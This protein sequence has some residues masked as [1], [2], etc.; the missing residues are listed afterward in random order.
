M[1][2]NKGTK[3]KA[4]DYGS[5]G[6]SPFGDWSAYPDN[7]LKDWVATGGL[8]QDI[9]DSATRAKELLS[10]GV[11]TPPQGMTVEDAI[12]SINRGL[13]DAESALADASKFLDNAG[14][15][16]PNLNASNDT[17]DLS[18]TGGA[19]AGQTLTPDQDAL[20][21]SVLR[22][23][24]TNTIGHTNA[25]GLGNVQLNNLLDMSDSETGRSLTIWER[26]T[27]RYYGKNNDRLLFLAR[28]EFIRQEAA[29]KLKK[30][31]A[32]PLAVATPSE[33]KTPPAKMQ[34]ASWRN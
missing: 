12:D 20:S 1:M 19:T 10:A 14:N 28:L 15:G 7:P 29:Q 2:A 34:P 11:A 23:G 32:P 21:G 27:R 6:W 8:P 3:D 25:T 16:S 22:K 33:K 30:S 13:L 26:A 17:S 4:S 5:T 9:K 24:K 18:G 31:S